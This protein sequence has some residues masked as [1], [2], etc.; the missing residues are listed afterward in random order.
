MPPVYT[1]E[2][3]DSSCCGMAGSFGYEKE[4]YDL[5]MKI[6]ELRL[7][8]EIRKRTGDFEVVVAGVSCREQ[9]KHGTGKEPRH[10][11]ELMSDAIYRR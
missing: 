6:G 1:V 10:L 5:S 3:I 2:A 11:I 9:I 8:G 4:H 7:F